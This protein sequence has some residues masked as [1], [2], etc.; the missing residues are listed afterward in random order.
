MEQTLALE[1]QPPKPMRRVD[2]FG[3]M[4]FIFTQVFLVRMREQPEICEFIICISQSKTDKSMR[5]TLPLKHDQCKDETP[6][7]ED[8]IMI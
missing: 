8:F 2:L 7:L 4:Q 3:R 6:N 5:E 1:W